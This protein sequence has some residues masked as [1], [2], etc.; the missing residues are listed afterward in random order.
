MRHEEACVHA[1]D[2]YQRAKHEIALAICST[3]PGAEMR[4]GPFFT[5]ICYLFSRI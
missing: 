5:T 2:G 1:A 4:R 3:G